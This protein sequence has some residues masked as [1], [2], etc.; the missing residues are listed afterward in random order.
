M[1]K[2][3][4]RL[5]GDAPD[6]QN[7]D[8]KFVPPAPEGK[9][10]Y[11]P[12]PPPKPNPKDAGVFTE[13]MLQ[14][15]GGKMK[16]PPYD[17]EGKKHG[18]AI[19]KRRFA[20]GGEVEDKE[21]GL[22][23]SNKEEP[24][25]FFKRLMMGNIDQPGSEAYNKFGAGRGKAESTAAARNQQQNANIRDANMALDVAEPVRT[26]SPRYNLED[27]R[28]AQDYAK[29][30]GGPSADREKAQSYADEFGVSSGSSKIK[31]SVSKPKV[32]SSNTPKKESKLSDYPVFTTP[33]YKPKKAEE[34]DLPKVA[35]SAASASNRGN[36]FEVPAAPKVKAG[37]GEIPTR[38]I[39]TP[40]S[41]DYQGPNELEK[42]IQGVPGG[43]A[44]LAGIAA[45]S[46]AGGVGGAKLYKMYK[47]A[48]RAKELDAA[49]RFSQ[50]GA[51]EITKDLSK[52]TGKEELEAAESTLRGANS[53]KGI[54]ERRSNSEIEYKRGGNVKA[55][56]KGG[57]VS[58]SSRGD[59]CAQRG[60]TRGKYI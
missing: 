24:V 45:L 34:K 47:A 50:P 33:E 43:G 10:K 54:Q 55:Y 59:G 42:I 2:P 38:D 22:A 39:A 25:G 11:T 4:N 44:S 30:V 49:K 31:P 13:E 51:R 7:P 15:S 23:A 32:S 41:T 21:A 35:A 6:G 37:T 52:Y 9:W 8:K 19:K 48:Q 60:H 53:R 28:K 16:A 57:A 18:G 56:A 20:G 5:T 3:V 29:D 27:F 46:A 36:S 26:A 14:R 58:S 1:A 12:P 40:K 17:P